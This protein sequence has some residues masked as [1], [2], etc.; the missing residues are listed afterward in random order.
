MEQVKL[1]KVLESY[2]K[3]KVV[4]NLQSFNNAEICQN[5]FNV[6]ISS[7]LKMLQKIHEK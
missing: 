4:M 6:W 5:Y 2:P 3:L 7:V 1:M